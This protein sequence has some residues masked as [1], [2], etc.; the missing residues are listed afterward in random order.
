MSDLYLDFDFEPQS[1]ESATSHYIPR[2]IPFQ[3]NESSTFPVTQDPNVTDYFK[4]YFIV[5]DQ[6]WRETKR[7]A[8]QYM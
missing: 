1:R 6:I 2:N 8:Q 4:M 5:I 3:V 7:Y